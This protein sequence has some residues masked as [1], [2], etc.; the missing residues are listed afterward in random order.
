MNLV[1]MKE[2]LSL[3]AQVVSHIYRGPEA[4]MIAP[5]MLY[6]CTQIIFVILT[7]I[8]ALELHVQLKPA[9]VSAVDLR[10]HPT[11]TVN[12]LALLT[13]HIIRHFKF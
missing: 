9:N 10:L 11:Y 6:C 5:I 3:L 4:S 7:Q 12:T 1:E 13:L 2:L 8:N